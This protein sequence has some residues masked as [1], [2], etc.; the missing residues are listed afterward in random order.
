[1]SNLSGA[2]L[3]ESMDAFS[4]E[5]YDPSGAVVDR[6]EE[7]ARMQVRILSPRPPPPADVAG[8]LVGHGRAAKATRSETSRAPLVLN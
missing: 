1:M 3:A 7:V 8:H 6:R 5:P 4:L 2:M